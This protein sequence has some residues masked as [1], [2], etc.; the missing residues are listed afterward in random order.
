[1]NL[2]PISQIYP[3]IGN[4]LKR[5]TS[6]YLQ[7]TSTN[8]KCEVKNLFNSCHGENSIA[9]DENVV[10][11]FPARVYDGIEDLAK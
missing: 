6:A 8:I 2:C 10:S 9:V 5:K 3:N 4:R 1:M 11:Y 7:S